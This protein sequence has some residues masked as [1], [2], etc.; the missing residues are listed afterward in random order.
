MM[1]FIFGYKVLDQRKVGFPISAFEKVKDSLEK[2][3]ISYQ[4]IYDDKEPFV[5]DIKKLNK[6]EYFYREALNLLDRQNRID[7][8]I[9]KLINSSEEDIEKIIRAIEYVQNKQ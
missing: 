9:N 6:Y 7:L 8:I 3:K 1:S 4:I 2:Y 5:K